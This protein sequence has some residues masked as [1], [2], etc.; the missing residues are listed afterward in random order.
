MTGAVGDICV[1]FRVGE[2][3]NDISWLT[4]YLIWSFVDYFCVSIMKLN[5]RGG[6]HDDSEAFVCVTAVY[7]VLVEHGCL[8]LHLLQANRHQTP[9]YTSFL[10]LSVIGWTFCRSVCED[11]SVT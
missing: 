6:F 2:D 8:Y 7:S 10:C 3:K 4:G 5:K 11:R 9:A 1:S